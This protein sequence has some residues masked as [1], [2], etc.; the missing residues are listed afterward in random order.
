MHSVRVSN[1]TLV[2]N[3]F[4]AN[5]QVKLVVRKVVLGDQP[6]LFHFGRNWHEN[7]SESREGLAPK[8]CGNSGD[9]EEDEKRQKGGDS[10]LGF[11]GTV[12]DRPGRGPFRWKPNGFPLARLLL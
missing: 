7:R 5:R 9:R 6:S 12:N 11:R 8:H 3:L 2:E 10:S 1:L 4:T